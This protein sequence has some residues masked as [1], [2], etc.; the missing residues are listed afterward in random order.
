MTANKQVKIIAVVG[1]AGSGK[2]ESCQFFR[3]KGFPILRFGDQT[4][5]GLREVGLPRTEKN[6]RQYR[7]QLRQE[8]GMAA[9]AIKI[10]P[11]VAKTIQ[12]EKPKAVILDGLYSWEEYEYLKKYFPNLTLLA[13]YSQPTLRYQRLSHRPERKLT[14]R[15]VQQRDVA[16]IVN[17]NKG[18][19]IAFC[20][21][22]IVND[23]SM[24]HLYAQLE[25][26]LSSI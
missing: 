9:Y 16:E 26:F 18:G 5:I 11:R 3:S 13:I 19:P 25:E 14:I 2:S 20:D 7:E 21:Y 15:E 10:K 22:L 24:D 23:G 17:S 8:L 12:S 1:M 4:D 6:E